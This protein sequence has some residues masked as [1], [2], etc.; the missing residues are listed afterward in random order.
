M[1]ICYVFL[2]FSTGGLSDGEAGDFYFVDLL[3]ESEEVLGVSG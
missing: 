3:G 2:H 1:H